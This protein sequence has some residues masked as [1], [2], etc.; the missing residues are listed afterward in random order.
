MQLKAGFLASNH[1]SHFHPSLPWIIKGIVWIGQ[2]NS[3]FTV[4]GPRRILT[5]FP[6]L[7][8]LFQRNL[9]YGQY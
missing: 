1:H 8:P 7:D 9:K 4:A 2:E 5:G 6:L 3:L